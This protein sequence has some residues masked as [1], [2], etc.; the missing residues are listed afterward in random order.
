VSVSTDLLCAGVAIFRGLGRLAHWHKGAPR[1]AHGSGPEQT[2]LREGGCQTQARKAAAFLSGGSTRDACGNPGTQGA[3][4]PAAVREGSQ[5]R[6]LRSAAA[7]ERRDV[8]GVRPEHGLSNANFISA[9]CGI[10]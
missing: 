1:R 3:A 7:K 6:D 8:S 2:A 5:A 10:T 9:A 4:K